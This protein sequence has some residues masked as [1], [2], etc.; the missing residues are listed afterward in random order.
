M[1]QKKYGGLNSIIILIS[2]GWQHDK[3]HTY[4]DKTSDK[5]TIL[6]FVNLYAMLCQ[7]ITT[8]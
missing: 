2:D 6:I 8:N 5:T 1:N 3:V 4:A 7:G